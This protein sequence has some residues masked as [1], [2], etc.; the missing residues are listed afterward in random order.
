MRTIYALCIGNE[1]GNAERT[2][3]MFEGLESAIQEA[4]ERNIFRLSCGELLE[5]DGVSRWKQDRG[6]DITELLNAG[7]TDKKLGKLAEEAQDRLGHYTSATELV[8]EVIAD[9]MEYWILPFNWWGV[10]EATLIEE[11]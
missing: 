8:D 1:K 4:R 6:E 2:H 9:C 11:D 10:A 7:L 5:E 3:I